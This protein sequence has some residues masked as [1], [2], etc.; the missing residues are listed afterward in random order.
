MKII[1]ASL[2]LAV[3]FAAT[4]IFAADEPETELGEHMEKLSGAYRRLGRQIGDATKNE[5]SLALVATI[6]AQATEARKLTPEL[7]A[8]KPEP[9]RPK[10]VAD[11]RKGI[12]GLLAVV[13]QLEAAL[14]AGDNKTAAELVAKMKTHQNDSHKIFRKPPPKKPDQPAPPAPAAG[15]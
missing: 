6:R 14:K 9:D 5:D 10:F 15:K 4:Q 7:T 12:D 8:E 1:R 3:A 2:L 11:F 13:D